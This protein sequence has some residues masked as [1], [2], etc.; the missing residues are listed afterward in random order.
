MQAG[1]R[2]KFEG[3]EIIFFSFLGDLD[4]FRNEIVIESFFFSFFFFLYFFLFFYEVHHL[5]TT[6]NK[7][8][9]KPK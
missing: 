1:R 3:I 7:I 9:I 8:K 4:Q 2:F 6:E 5:T